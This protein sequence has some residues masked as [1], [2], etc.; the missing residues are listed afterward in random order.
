MCVCV[1]VCARAH[2]RVFVYVNVYVCAPA[3]YGGMKVIL[4]IGDLDLQNQPDGGQWPDRLLEA[5]V[6]TGEATV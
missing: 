3:H 4:Y 1:F 2:A 5:E 6:V